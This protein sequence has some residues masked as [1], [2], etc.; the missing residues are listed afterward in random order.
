MNQNTLWYEHTYGPIRAKVEEWIW[1]DDHRPKSDY[2][3]NWEEHDNFRS[4][5]MTG[6]VC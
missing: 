3:A 2:L 1:Y 4:K 5:N 6:I